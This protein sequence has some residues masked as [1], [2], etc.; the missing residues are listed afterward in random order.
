[1]KCLIQGC[2]KRTQ[3]RGLC[4]SHYQV[5]VISVR[6][7]ETTWIE[8]ERLGMATIAKRAPR[9]KKRLAFDE[10]LATLR[11]KK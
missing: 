3:S 5:A 7:G 6:N 10:Q 9:G 4:S 2:G 8:L 11:K 1:M